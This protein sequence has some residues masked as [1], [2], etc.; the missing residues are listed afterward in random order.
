MWVLI[1]PKELWIVVYF[2]FSSLRLSGKQD[3]NN[4]EEQSAK[5]ESLTGMDKIRNLCRILKP[6]R[7]KYAAGNEISFD[8]LHFSSFIVVQ[9]QINSGSHQQW[10]YCLI[11]WCETEIMSQRVIPVIY[12]SHSYW[13]DLEM[14]EVQNWDRRQYQLDIFIGEWVCLCLWCCLSSEGNISCWMLLFLLLIAPPLPPTPPPALV[15]C[16]STCSFAWG[17]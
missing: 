4:R 17:G 8:K 11:Y 3:N 13:F 10:R 15:P 16:T 6:R 1:L 14:N 5:C 7:D 9:R 2:C 12:P